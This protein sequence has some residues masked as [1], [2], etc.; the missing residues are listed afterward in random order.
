LTVRPVSTGRMFEK[1]RLLLF[2]GI[3]CGAASSALA[4]HS[5]HRDWWHEKGAAVVEHDYA[6]N[7]T[8]CSLFLYN[9]DQA[10]VVTWGYMGVKEICFFD[11]EWHFQTSQPVAVDVQ[12]GDTWLHA[13]VDPGAPGLMGSANQDQV[14]VPVQQPLEELLRKATQ[15]SVK[16][17]DR[18]MSINVENRRMAARMRAVERCRGMLHYR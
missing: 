2:I 13:P 12:V 8:A 7:E 1:R 18:T 9:K 16:L 6:R 4:Q 17:G 5:R 3:L 14:S 11:K 15:I 10:V